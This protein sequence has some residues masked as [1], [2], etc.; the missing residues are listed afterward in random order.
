MKTLKTA[1]YLADLMLLSSSSNEYTTSLMGSA[2]LFIAI[3]MNKTTISEVRNLIFEK[4][5]GLY[6]RMRE[7]LRAMAHL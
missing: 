2:C 4:F 7:S 3:E 5:I 1:L 6:A